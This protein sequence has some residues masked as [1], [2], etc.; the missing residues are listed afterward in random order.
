MA[1]TRQILPTAS[2]EHTLLELYGPASPENRW[3]L[4]STDEDGENHFTWDEYFCPA[5]MLEIKTRSACVM[6][7]NQGDGVY[8]LTVYD[9]DERRGVWLYNR[10]RSPIVSWW[11]GG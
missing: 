8:M 10:R 11:P 5:V 6:H 2:V 7:G 4:I 3:L 9:R 1:R